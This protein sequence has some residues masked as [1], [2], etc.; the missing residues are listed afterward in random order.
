VS[1]NDD[2]GITYSLISVTSNEPD[3]GLSLEDL[4]NDIVIVNS[5][6]FRLRAER[7]ENGPGR[8]YT[9]TYQATDACGN[10][11]VASA[12][13]FVPHNQGN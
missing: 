5:T 3:S 7:D 12:T 4:P 8:T 13:V 6:T 2:P 11:T 1:D 10:T 9:V